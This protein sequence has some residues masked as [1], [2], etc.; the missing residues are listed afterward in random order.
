MKY[1]SLLLLLGLLAAPVLPAQSPVPPVFTPTPVNVVYQFTFSSTCSA[2]SDGSK[3]NPTSYLW[4]PEKCKKV[5]GLIVIS[6][7]VPE[8][9][10][11]AHPKVREACA[12]NDLGIVYGG[13]L[14]SFSPTPPGGKSMI[15]EWSS[16]VAGLQQQLD[17]L[18]KV[19]G[20]AE[21]ATV[22][23]LPIGESTNLL[24][25]DALLEAAPQHCIAG[26]FVKNFHLPP[27]KRLAP[28]L[29]LCGTAQEWS[30]DK[31]DIRTS[32]NNVS[33]TYEGVVNERKNNPDFALSFVIDG[34]SGHF[35]CSERLTRYIA[36]Y[37]DAVAKARL[38]TDGSVNLKPVDLNSGYVADLP[39]PGHE[40]QPVI[41]FAKT[42]PAQ[43]ALSWYFDA[44]SAKE[45]Q[46][47]ASINWKAESQLPGFIDEQGKVLPFD[48]NGITDIK[49]LKAEPDG[50]TFSVRG[51]MMDRIPGNFVG[52]GEKLAQTPGAPEAEWLNGSFEPLGK[53]RFR[54]VMAGVGGSGYVTL[55]KSGTATIRGSVQPARIDLDSLRIKDGKPQ[56]ITFAPI[57]DV[58]AGTPSVPLVATSD[59]RL[60]VQ[61]YVEYGPA[62]VRDGKV[63][64]TAI[65]PRS[66]FPIEVKVVAWQWGRPSEPK[67]Q[68]ASLVKQT[69]RLLAP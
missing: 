55:R 54:I 45:A 52:A 35:D 29:V 47:I 68:T 22:P 18:A 20:Y 7:N 62:I 42:A 14:L 49:T 19:S 36:H 9:G 13:G 10:I 37:I 69:F 6:P 32:W 57:A 11:A 31:A 51:T 44:A 66:Q 61:F 63:V 56:K 34:H 48:F 1:P 53:G 27:T 3:T 40:N 16:V 23:W 21:V 24:M 30:Q 28:A 26:I 38:S 5:R 64:F 8:Q 60:P 39:V 43:R 33:K 12:A 58:K 67:V 65:P 50:M 17:G 15:R 2:W 41:P 59:A 25:V 46:A 4:I